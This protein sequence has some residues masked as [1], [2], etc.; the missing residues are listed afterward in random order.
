MSGFKTIVYDSNDGIASI[1]LNRPEVLNAYN[2]E[3][4][5]ELYQVIEAIRDDPEIRIVVFS[6]AGDRAFCVG[7]DLSEFLTAPSPI[8]ARQA[9]WG[10]DIWGQFLSLTKPLVAAL[11]G[12]VFGSGLEISL[13]CDLRIASEDAIFS[14]PEVGLGIIPAAGGTQTLARGIGQA[15]ALE[16]M[17]TGRMINATE[18]YRMKIVNKVVPRSRLMEETNHVAQKIKSLDPVLVSNAKQA[19]NRGFDLN[20]EQGLELERRLAYYI[21]ANNKPR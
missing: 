10:R 5:D 17:L 8:V 9:R 1:M 12:Y 15:A 19:I 13:Y 20:L 7:A 21:S 6:G 3:M 16:M 2:L 4:R 11:H 14:L 18:A